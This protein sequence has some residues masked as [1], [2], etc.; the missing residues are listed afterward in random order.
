VELGTRRLLEL[1]ADDRIAGVKFTASDLF[2]FWKLRTAAP[3]KSFFFGTDE[4]FLAA[5]ATGTDG[6]IGITYN[7]IG[8]VYR[9][10]SDAVARGDLDA[11]RTLQARSS[12]LVKGL[13]KTGVLPSLKYAMNRLGIP[14]GQ[15]RAPFHA[16]DAQS[17]QRL[18]AWMDEHLSPE[19]RLFAT[20]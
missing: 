17:L 13:L 10:I 6:G 16:P 15:C 19:Q 8:N 3:G 4:M 5:S 2:Q 20:A 18:D 1:L 11:A 9:G 7:L 14:V 12:S